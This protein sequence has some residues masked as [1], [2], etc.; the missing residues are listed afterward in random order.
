MSVLQKQ[1]GWLHAVILTAG[2]P[3]F[4]Q[5][6]VSCSAT[7]LFFSPT[8]LAPTVTR[9]TCLREHPG[10]NLDRGQETILAF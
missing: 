1:T 7:Q 9:L 5:L 2:R 8:E 4:S 10:S 3:M 6:P